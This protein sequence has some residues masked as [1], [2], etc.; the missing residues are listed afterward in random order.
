MENMIAELDDVHLGLHSKADDGML[1]R[2]G[3]A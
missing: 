2:E 1:L 3:Q